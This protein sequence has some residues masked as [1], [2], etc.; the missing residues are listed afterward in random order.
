MRNSPTPTEEIAAEWNKNAV[1]R[2]RQIV[3][4]IDI[5]YHRI[6][7]PTI[8]RLVG[9]TR[10]K[11]VI[12]VG[13][14]SGYL[15][16]KLAT[17]ASRVVGVDPSKRMIEIAEHDYAKVPR[18]KFYNLSIEDFA[19]E[20]A[21]AQFDV[22]VS[23][24]SL[25][26]IPNLAAAF[27]AISATLVPEGIFAFNITH[28]C[29]WNEHRKYEES[30]R[31]RYQVPHAQKGKFIISHDSQG[32]PSPTTHFHRPLEE[33]FRSMHCASLVVDDLV[34]PFPSPNVERLYPEPWKTPRFL[35]IRCIKRG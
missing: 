33:Y 27:M 19:K 7:I 4:E 34:E 16:S 28:P 12:D 26:T 13:C 15:S 6:L 21:D 5:S 32:L 9:D 10:N 14:G 20:H 17:N 30:D 18:L 29:F 1:A 8:L 23:N 24:M 11:G 25:I 35:S 3:S 2:H 22:A 31:F